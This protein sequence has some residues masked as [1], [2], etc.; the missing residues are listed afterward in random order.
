MRNNRKFTL[1][2]VIGL[3]LSLGMASAAFAA[4]SDKKK[5]KKQP[6]NTGI[7]SVTTTPNALPVR[8]DGQLLGMSGVGEAAEFYLT[9]GIHRVEIEGPN[10]QSF[11]RDIN[12]V[13]KVKNCI[14]L[15]VVE[16]TTSRPCPYDMRVDGPESVTEGDLVT[17][18]ARNVAAVT[19]IEASALNYAWRVSPS[20]ARI[21]SGLG[22]PAITV[23]T[24][25]LGNRTLMVELDVTDGVYDAS[26]R[27]RISIDTEVVRPPDPQPKVCILFDEF[28]FRSFDDD[29]ARMDNLA[30][31]LQNNPTWNGYIIMYQGTDRK[32]QT[33]GEVGRLT[34]RALDYLVKT[35][36]VD[37]SRIQIVRGGSRPTTTYQFWLCPPGAE[38]PVPN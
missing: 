11:S 18:V 38:V 24:S 2:F 10:G 25:G 16:N 6:K 27:Q 26:C 22:T 32:S 3:I 7:L 13:K 21:T 8:V 37:P 17:F 4:G 5:K 28:P 15:N 9:P 36:G 1:L 20:T 29:K 33:A 23:D 12:I 31:E 35:R 19:A 14:C 34:R 30:I